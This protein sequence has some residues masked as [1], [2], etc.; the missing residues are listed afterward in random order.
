MRTSRIQSFLSLL[1]GTLLLPSPG[2]ASPAG[3]GG[4]SPAPPLAAGVDDRAPADAGPRLHHLLRQ[5]NGRTVHAPDPSLPEPRRPSTSGAGG[6]P[7]G[8]SARSENGERVV[9]FPLAHTRVY[10]Q[11]SGNVA[12]VEV[13]QLYRNPTGRR[14]EAVYAFPL[15]PN[16]AVTDM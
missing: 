13:T 10:A 2:S 11:V 5:A 9:E 12:R 3:P 1:A 4:A 16:A 6:P 15:P 7:A 14:L 8:F